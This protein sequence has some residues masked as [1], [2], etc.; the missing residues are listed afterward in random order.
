MWGR[1]GAFLS[2]AP[3]KRAAKEMGGEYFIQF[4]ASLGLTRR[5]PVHRIKAPA[6]PEEGEEA[7]THGNETTSL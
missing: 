3:E 4:K 7:R 6:Y 5:I 1:G 2:Y